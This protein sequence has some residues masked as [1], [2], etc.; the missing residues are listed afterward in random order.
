MGPSWQVPRA[1][2][3]GRRAWAAAS[4][5]WMAQHRVP[6]TW[7]REVTLLACDGARPPESASNLCPQGIGRL[8]VGRPEQCHLQ[9]LGYPTRFPTWPEAASGIWAQGWAGDGT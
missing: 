8:A 2:V 1:P 7:R 3:G 9:L 5:D 4:T 6:A